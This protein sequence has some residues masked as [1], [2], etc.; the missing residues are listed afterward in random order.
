MQNAE[1][2]LG[3]LCER[4]K[5]K[6]PCTE[7]YRQMFNPQLYL[8]AYGRIYPN[9]GAMTAGVTG[10]TADGMSLA[11]IEK[12]I[13]ALRHER[14]RFDP[15]KRTHIPKKN[16]KTRPLGLPS[17]TDK[18]VGEV[19]RLLLEAYY[20][21]QF[22]DHSHGFR[23]RRGC[24]TAL[25]HVSIAWTG[26]TWFIEGDIAR[27]FDSLDHEVM[28]EIL[29]ENIQDNRF[30]RLVRNMLEAGYLEDW[31]WNATLSGTP[32]G[33]V[34][35][36]ILSNIYLHKLDAFIE[37]TL[38]PEYT[39]GVHRARNPEYRQIEYAIKRARRRGD[40]TEVRELQSRLRKTPSQMMSD[41]GFRRLR[42][43]RYADDTLLGLI[44]TKA[45]AEEIKRRLATFLREDLKL[46]LSAEKTLITHA[47]TGAARFLGYDVTVHK[48]DGRSEPKGGSRKGRRST[49][50]MVRLRVPTDV[51]K[52]KCAP[53]MKRGKPARM[54]E[55]YK[56]DDFTLV[57]IYSARYRGV[58]QYYLLAGDVFRLNRLHWVM[59]SSLL[60]SLAN[61]RRSTMTKVARKYKATIDTSV[62][63]RKCIQVS[64]PRGPG[65]EPLTARFGGIPLRRQKHA[66]L[67]DRDPVQPRHPQREIVG[68]LLSGICELCGGSARTETHQV[69]KL[70]DLDR[71]REDR[72]AW[73][74]LMARKRRKTLVVCRRCHEDIHSGATAK[75]AE[76]VIGEPDA[77]KVARPV[78]EEAAGKRTDRSRSAPR[79]AAH[80]TLCTEESVEL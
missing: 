58:V 40:R 36:P 20:E 24:H 70:S 39:R 80:L 8:I 14:F 7:L 77:M 30:L 2:V 11:K 9:K 65:K 74:V 73:V 48:D 59:Q 55:L 78:R 29:G 6:L 52:A 63:P 15:V 64:I 5:R 49:N 57:N 31:R 72:P 37:T 1:T 75:G 33:G 27:C 16:G 4:G 3:V 23:P 22:S 38:I 21:P 62:G 12:I 79:P 26:T 46:E 71:Y 76:R 18:L 43:V 56:Y 10:E 35:S 68:R 25:R 42:Y 54:P 69:S 60:C 41:P 13:D 50:G 61:K 45:E 53:Y 34:L 17:W 51:I 66:A 28:I 19:M 44:G 47:R 67:P 32:Q